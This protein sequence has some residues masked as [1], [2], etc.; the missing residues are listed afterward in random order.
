MPIKLPVPTLLLLADVLHAEAL[1]VE[2]VQLLK[3]DSCPS[4]R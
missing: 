1:R 3:R 2:G 4:S